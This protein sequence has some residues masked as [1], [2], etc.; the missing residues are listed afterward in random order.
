MRINSP[1]TLLVLDWDGTVAKTDT[2]SLIAPS[3]EALKPYT[4]AYMADYTALSDAH[5]PRDT[6]DKME[7]WLDAMQRASALFS[8]SARKA[9]RESTATS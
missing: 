3:P 7:R 4:E 5:G 9:L 6:M 1:R 8:S 2:L